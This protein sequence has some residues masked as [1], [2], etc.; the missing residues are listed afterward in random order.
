MINVLK[1]KRPSFW[2]LVVGVIT[3]IIISI[4]LISNSINKKSG[5]TGGFQK[6][7]NFRKK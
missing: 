5:N 4:G 7:K 6:V 2:I 3:I 1:Y